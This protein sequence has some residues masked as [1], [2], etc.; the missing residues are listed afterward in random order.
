MSQIDD[1]LKENPY[2]DD[3]STL[4]KDAQVLLERS[5]N[6][7]NRSFRCSSKSRRPIILQRRNSLGSCYPSPVIKHERTFNGFPLTQDSI[8]FLKSNE[9]KGGSASSQSD[10]TESL[11]QHDNKENMRK[12][13]NKKITEKRKKK[14]TK[15]HPQKIAPQQK[16]LHIMPNGFISS[17][18][19][20][21]RSLYPAQPS[22]A[23]PILPKGH[24]A[25]KIGSGKDTRSVFFYFYFLDVLS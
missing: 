7:R 17:S 19:A 12:P 5:A 25:Q 18:D 1:D 23:C 21:S 16:T 6:R 10:K 13:Q 14:P 15:K 22:N 3:T 2:P 20:I 11:H 9:K 8:D 24:Q 4:I